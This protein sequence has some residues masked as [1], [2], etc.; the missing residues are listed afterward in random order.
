MQHWLLIMTGLMLGLGAALPP[1]AAQTTP[2]ET[3]ECEVLV[4][5]GGLGGIAAALE[6]L[7]LERKVCLTEITDWIGGQVSQQGVSALDERPLQRENDLFAQGYL[8]FRARVRQDYGGVSNPGQ[9]WVSVLCFSPRV[10]VEVLDDML[11]PY[12][13]SGRLVLLTN[14]VIKGLDTEAG[15]IRS[16]TALMHGERDPEQGVNSLPLSH[17]IQDWYDPRPSELFTKRL[18]RLV[19]PP[20]REGSRLKWIV[21]DAT[22]T[23]E[24]LPLA[25]VPYRLGTDLQNRWEPSASPLGTDPYCTQGFTYTFVMEQTAIPEVSIKPADYESPYNKLY[26]SYEKERFDFASIFTYRRIR[27]TVPGM[28]VGALRDGDQ[29]MQNWTWGNDWRLSTPTTNLVLTQSQLEEEGQLQKGNWRGGLRTEALASAEAHALGYYYWLVAGR[30][31]SQLQKINPDYRKDYYFRYAFLK[32]RES[33]MGTEHGLSRYPYIREGRRIIGRTS[34]SYPDGFTI[35]ETDISRERSLHPGRPYLFFDS[36]GIGQYNID[37]HACLKENLEP[38]PYEAREAPAPSYPYQVPLRALIPQRID[39][40]LAG[41]KNIATSHITNGSYRVHPIEWSIGAA[42]GNT[43]AFALVR[44][45][46]PAE[47]V[48]GASDRL[49]NALQAQIISQGNPIQF[50]GMTIFTTQWADHK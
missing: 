33:P 42:A 23:G 10:G 6:A 16:A 46:F 22:E 2:P 12:R 20:A 35:Y 17:F 26:Y 48:S 47:L 38:S 9:C 29:S 50:P 34:T 25:G 41:N 36:V 5:G 8:E 14:T 7:R 3:I 21:I 31:D 40:L 13:R 1:A 27:G 19:P 39:N 24:L 43:A 32:G 44:N 4:A 37:F 15:Q 18:V 11:A 49:L 30:S 28:G 45:L